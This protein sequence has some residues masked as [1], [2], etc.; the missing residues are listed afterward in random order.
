[1]HLSQRSKIINNNALRRKKCVWVNHILASLVSETHWNEYGCGKLWPFLHQE[2]GDH[3]MQPVHQTVNSSLLLLVLA[4]V[5]TI[6][7]SSCGVNSGNNIFAITARNDFQNTTVIGTG[8]DITVPVIVN[9]DIIQ[10]VSIS[11]SNTGLSGRPFNFDPGVTPYNTSTDLSYHINGG[12]PNVAGFPDPADKAGSVTLDPDSNLTQPET[13]Q[14]IYSPTGGGYGVDWFSYTPRGINNFQDTA[15]VFV[16]YVRIEQDQYEPDDF[17]Q[18]ARDINDFIFPVGTHHRETHNSDYHNPAPRT[19]GAVY[20]CLP[21]MT[22]AGDRDWWKFDIPSGANNLSLTVKAGTPH[23]QD[24]S[25]RGSFQ[26][27]ENELCITLIAEETGEPP[28][29]TDGF[30]DL[31]IAQRYTQNCHPLFSISPRPY[32][33]GSDPGGGFEPLIQLNRNAK[34]P[35]PDSLFFKWRLDA[36]SGFLVRRRVFIRINPRPS[37]YSGPCNLANPVYQPHGEYRVEFWLE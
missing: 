1:M 2:P 10:L 14:L 19:C 16:R 22:I 20:N 15:Y 21:G 29:Q 33:F 7:L 6:A 8:G 13:V 3:C 9:D 28:V 30:A 35:I 36:S 17:I 34:T 31:P 18:F 37:I 23:H 27:I 5:A 32:W 24:Y 12:N 4:F 11:H 25:D 26:D